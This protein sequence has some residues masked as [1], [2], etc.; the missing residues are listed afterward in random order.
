MLLCQP[1]MFLPSSRLY[2]SF[3]LSW[4]MRCISTPCTKTKRDFEVSRYFACYLIFENTCSPPSCTINQLIYWRFISKMRYS[5]IRFTKM[6]TGRT[7]LEVS[8]RGNF[9]TFRQMKG[10]FALL[11]KSLLSL[12][13]FATWK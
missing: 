7:V 12:S 9:L 4:V 11:C 1:S 6:R 13:A 2:L 5:K 3:P 8:S 10:Y